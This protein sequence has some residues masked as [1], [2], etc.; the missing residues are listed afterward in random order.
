ML[1]QDKKQQKT[2]I[3]KAKKKEIQAMI[4]E[5]NAL[6]KAYLEET[7]IEHELPR[8]GQEV[9]NYKG[10]TECMT[11]EPFNELRLTTCQYWMILS[12]RKKNGEWAKKSSGHGA[13][14]SYPNWWNYG[15]LTGWHN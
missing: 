10:E 2:E 8:L 11:T 9:K 7:A 12:K 14:Q 5:Y 3:L 6:H 4:D 15:D 1:P 13:H